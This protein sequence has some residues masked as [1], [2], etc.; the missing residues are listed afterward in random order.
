MK[1]TLII[2]GTIATI[3]I[4]YFSLAETVT[5]NWTAPTEYSDNSPLNPE[6]LEQFKIYC[7]DDAPIFVEPDKRSHNVTLFPGTYTCHVTTSARGQESD[8][9]EA[10][11]KVVGWPVSE[12]SLE[13]KAS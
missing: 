9:S 7:N 11:T 3:L 5:F 13:N 12:S 1:I 8:A 10:T 6:D 4:G 2:T